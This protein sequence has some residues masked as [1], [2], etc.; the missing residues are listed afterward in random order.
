MSYIFMMVT[1]ISFWH[2]ASTPTV[3]TMHGHT[4]L[5]DLSSVFQEFAD[6]PLASISDRQRSRCHS[7]TGLA[8]STTDFPRAFILSASIR[9]TTWFF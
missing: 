8:P 2:A 5:P 6:M 3:T 7:Q 1:S 4:D 9:K